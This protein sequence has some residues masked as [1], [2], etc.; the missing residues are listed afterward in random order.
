MKIGIV[1]TWFERGAAY[2]SRQFKDILEEQNQVFVYARGGEKFA[3]GDPNWDYDYVTWGKAPLTHAFTDI[4][5]KDFEKW[6]KEKQLDLVL[7]NEQKIWAPVLLCRELSVLTGAYIDYYTE[8]T[9]PMFGLY[10]FLICNTKKHHSV[11]DWHEQCIFLPWGTDTDLYRPE[12]GV[13]EPERIRFFHSAGMNPFRKGTDLLLKAFSK[14]QGEAKLV[15]HSQV[16]IQS[17]FPE[18]EQLILSLKS[19]D[20]LEIHERTVG[21]PGLYTKG[22]VYVYPTR[23]EGIGLTILEAASSGL[24]VIVPDYDPMNEFVDSSINGK[25]VK[26]D[27]FWSRWDGYYWPQCEVGVFDLTEKM[28]FYVDNKLSIS[29]F[30]ADAREYALL[31]FNWKHNTSSLNQEITKIR[32]IESKGFSEILIKAKNYDQKLFQQHK[33]STKKLFSEAIEFNYPRAFMVIKKLKSMLRS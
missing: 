25:V 20:R 3:I 31:N 8:Q 6:I 26:I 29:Q 17:F 18:L 2:V 7:F 22:D 1:T 12:N 32:Q 21:A 30:K 23:L 28:Q 4:N 14:I 33:K 13:N 5:L 27:K 10:D 11:F 24:P 16:S 9:V 15:I 19:Q